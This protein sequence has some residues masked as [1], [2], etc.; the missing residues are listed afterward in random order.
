MASGHEPTLSATG[1][2]HLHISAGCDDTGPF[3]AK[4]ELLGVKVMPIEGDFAA[5]A[6]K[7]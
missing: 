4:L 1:R 6:G 5:V 3:S 2:D 7:N